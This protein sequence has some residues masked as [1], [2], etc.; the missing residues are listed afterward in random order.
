MIILGLTGSIA[1]G[2]STAAAMFRRLGVP[3]YD[4]DREVH[5]LLGRN[6][7]AVP[8]IDRTFPGVV[9]DGAVDRARLGAQV[10]D[11][12][13]PCASWRILHPLV[14]ARRKVFLRT[15]ARRRCRLVVLDI[16]LLYETRGERLCDAVAVVSA[17]RFLQE[18]RLLRRPG[19]DRARLM[20]ILRQQLP[21]AV[22]RRRADFIIP[23]GL[24]RTPTFLA[25]RRIVRTLARRERGKWARSHTSMKLDR[26]RS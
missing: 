13:P 3:V 20:A 17:P 15:A 9:I 14:A 22:K 26:R 12:P 24:G 6:G 18:I 11:D 23:S 5:R 19:M 25:I 10:F 4:A 16:P 2:K 8:L 7:A 1:M 21:D